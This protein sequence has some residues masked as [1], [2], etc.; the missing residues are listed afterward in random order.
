MPVS[1]EKW[2][3]A[4]MKNTIKDTTEM[5]QKNC[6]HLPNLNILDRLNRDMSMPPTK[7]RK[8]QKTGG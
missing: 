6:I 5:L 8:A 7:I 1:R 2:L 4:N 3:T